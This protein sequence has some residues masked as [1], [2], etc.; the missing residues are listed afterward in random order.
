M[1]TRRAKKCCYRA[2]LGD[3]ETVQNIVVM[4]VPDH[5]RLGDWTMEL[6]IGQSP[7]GWRSSRMS[8]AVSWLCAVPRAVSCPWRGLYYWTLYRHLGMISLEYF[9]CL[10]WQ[11]LPMTDISACSLIIIPKFESRESDPRSPTN[12]PRCEKI[13]VERPDKAPP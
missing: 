13:L 6:V 8:G 9:Y 3:I 2:L 1:A 4:T 7:P 5:C 10:V 11:I 12:L